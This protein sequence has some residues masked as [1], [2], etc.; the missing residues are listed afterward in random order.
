M[1]LDDK[2]DLDELLDMMVHGL[3][4]LSGANNHNKSRK[5]KH[6]DYRKYILYKEK[7]YLDQ[8]EDE[9]VQIKPPFRP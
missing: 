1:D 9:G 7:R 6:K 5:L 3:K 8:I 2:S 4:A